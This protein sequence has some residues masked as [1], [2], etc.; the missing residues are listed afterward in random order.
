M[1]ITFWFAVVCFVKA[2][3]INKFVEKNRNKNMDRN[4]A[5]IAMF[6]Y[7][8]L[9]NVMKTIECLTKNTLADDTELYVFSDGGKDE[10]SWQQVNAV[11]NFFRTGSFNLKRLRL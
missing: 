9:D 2:E 11:R 1:C 8:R 7:N 5:P 6:V 10:A 3:I 4:C